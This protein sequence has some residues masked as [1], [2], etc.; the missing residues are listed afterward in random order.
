MT[1]HEIRE[2]MAADPETLDTPTRVDHRS[3]RPKGTALAVLGAAL[4][5][6]VLVSTTLLVRHNNSAQTRSNVDRPASV[7]G[8][9]ISEPTTVGR[10]RAIVSVPGDWGRNEL[11]CGVTTADTVVFEFDGSRACRSTSPGFDSITIG[12][13]GGHDPHVEA[14]RTTV[15][16]VDVYTTPTRDQAGFT[17]IEKLIPEADAWFLIR[18]GSSELA[19]AIGDS[20][21]VLPGDQTTMPDVYLGAT[22]GIPGYFAAPGPAEVTR[23]LEHAGLAVNLRYIG[24]ARP[25]HWSSLT[26][27][28]KPGTVLRAGTKVTLTY[29]VGTKTS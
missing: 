1:T 9:G 15:N 10:G 27:D 21:R 17:V 13:A 19:Q 25:G 22:G 2:R 8:E 16:G 26:A 11:H 12:S 23:R 24:A 29:S 20:L 5:A 7:G 3:R 4:V 14:T 28:S 18:V 6:T